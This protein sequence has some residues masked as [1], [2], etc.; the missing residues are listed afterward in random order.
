[1]QRAVLGIPLLLAVVSGCASTNA[2]PEIRYL[3]PTDSPARASAVHVQQ[4]GQVVWQQLLAH[5][6]QSPLKIERADQL[7]GLIVTTYH[8]DPEPYVDCGW[9]MAYGPGDLHKT[10]GSTHEAAFD[11]AA[12]G[13]NE[14]LKRSLE[15][16]GRMVV[17]VKPAD[18][19]ALVAVDSTYVLTKT[20]ALEQPSASEPRSAT[21]FASFTSGQRGKFASGTVCQPTGKLERLALDGLSTDVVTA[22]GSLSP[23][24]GPAPAT[25]SAPSVA[26]L[27]CAGADQGYCQ[28]RDLIAPYRQANEQQGLGLA[29]KTLGGEGAVLTEGDVLTFD[30]SFP[31]FDSYLHVAYLQRSG[32][33]GH[34]LP[35]SARL[36]P[37]NVK[38]HVERTG[39]EIAPPYGVEMILAIATQ[40]PLF[41]TPRPQFEPAADYLAALRQRLAELAATTPGTQIA[42]DSLLIAT[43]PRRPGV[44]ASN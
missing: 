40:Q 14:V 27:D 33:V 11:R 17:Q 5:L 6:Q 44:S 32:V 36:W 21:E 34:V 29:I 20:V 12:D 19:D 25:P 15:L 39:Y 23:G 38:H 9:I 16:D 41:P 24:P 43:R 30:I 2:P 10:P 37:A 42:A 31:T 13:Q 35:G 3:R 28:A 8:G 18:P 7:A 22:G 1:M 4:S 26:G